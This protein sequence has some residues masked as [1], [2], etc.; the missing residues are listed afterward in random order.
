MIIGVMGYWYIDRDLNL[1]IRMACS[2]C[3]CVVHT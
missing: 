1:I 2:V 3:V